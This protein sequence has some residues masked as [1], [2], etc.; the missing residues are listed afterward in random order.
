MPNETKIC[1]NCKQDFI[2]EP[3]DFDFYNKIKVPPPTFCPECRMQR[4]FIFRNERVLYKRECDLCDRAVISIYPLKTEFPVYCL[5]CWWSD[6]W[7]ASA[8]F[9]KIDF[10][11]PLLE[12]MIEL[13]KIVPRPHT[14]NS[15]AARLV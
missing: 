7:D 14:N 4:R 1:Q 5:S 3:A 11:R 12:Q 13:R 10:T 8:Y 9:K 6:K 2:I 15:S